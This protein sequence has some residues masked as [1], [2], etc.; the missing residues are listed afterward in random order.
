MKAGVSV[1]Q[2]S[3]SPSEELSTLTI[4]NY[5]ERGYS[6]SVI[7]CAYFTPDNYS[8]TVNFTKNGSSSRPG[9]N[10]VTTNFTIDGEQLLQ[11]QCYFRIK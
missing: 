10:L 1:E 3:L 11:Y 9:N 8:E 6:G 4:T 2:R 5:R 7:E